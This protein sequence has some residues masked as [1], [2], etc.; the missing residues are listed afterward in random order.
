[1]LERRGQTVQAGMDKRVAALFEQHLREVRI[2][3]PRGQI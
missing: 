2:G 1:M 3:S